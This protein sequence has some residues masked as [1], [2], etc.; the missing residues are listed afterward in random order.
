MLMEE[1]GVQERAKKLTRY[2]SPT[3]DFQAPPDPTD[4]SCGRWEKVSVDR[5]TLVVLQAELSST[6]KQNL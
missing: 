5:S 2:P 3:V 4:P 1:K 6:G